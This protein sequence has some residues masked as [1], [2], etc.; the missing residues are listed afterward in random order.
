MSS[1]YPGQKAQEIAKATEKKY[2][3]ALHQLKKAE[4]KTNRVAE[5]YGKYQLEVMSQTVN[6]FIDFLEAIGQKT[7]L[8]QKKLLEGYTFQPHQLKEYK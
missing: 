1:F 8:K 6:A 4:A 2:K 7:T 3:S 5:S